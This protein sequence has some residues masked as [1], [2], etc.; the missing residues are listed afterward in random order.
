[1][2]KIGF[3]GA[4]DKTDLIIYVAKI[5]KE[6]GKKVL[7]IDST[8]LGKA[9]YIVPAISP[10]RL[11]ITSFEEIDVAI[12]FNSLEDIKEYLGIQELDYD[13]VLMDIDSPEEFEML[14]A[15]ENDKNYFVTAFDNYSLKRGLE[16]IGKQEEKIL[17][18]KVLFSKEMLKEEEDY[19]NFLSFYYSIQW[20]KDKLN[21][22]CENGDQSVII[23]NQRAAK[24]RFRNLSL[25][26]KTG[27]E[28]LA[29]QI[30]PDVKLNDIRRIMRSI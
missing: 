24:I 7:V 23:E 14:N 4:T 21:F 13:I 19:L 29:I 22:P 2:K 30:I 5:I 9:R 11:Y 20:D 8:V 10:S 25:D 17:L 16:I 28:S 18:T 6:T 15:K 27:L 3:I 1:M 12:G 26:Y